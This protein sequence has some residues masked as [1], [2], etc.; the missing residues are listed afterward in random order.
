MKL[1]LELEIEIGNWKS[2]SGDSQGSPGCHGL[3]T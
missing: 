2:K 1:E 3:V